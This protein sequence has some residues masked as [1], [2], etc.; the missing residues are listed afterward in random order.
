MTSCAE[1]LRKQKSNCHVFVVLLG[2]DRHK[3]DVPQHKT[4]RM[5]SLPYPTDLSLVIHDY[6]VKAVAVNF[7]KG[8]K[9]KRA[10]VII[11]GLVPTDNHQLDLFQHENPKH[12]SS[13]QRID[14]LNNKYETS[15]I[16]LGFKTYLEN[17]SKTPIAKIHDKY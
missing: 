4:S 16:K 12:K 3:I 2:S 7:K 1:K 9:Y 11:T 15:K 5:V 8:L 13:M 10:G 14:M 17:A 6:A